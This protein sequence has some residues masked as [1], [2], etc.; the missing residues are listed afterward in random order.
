[1]CHFL[2]LPAEVRNSIYEY[3]LTFPHGL[4]YYHDPCFATDH[5]QVADADSLTNP[6]AHWEPEDHAFLITQDA[7]QLKIVSKQLHSE[8]YSLVLRFNDIVFYD[9]QD[10]TLFLTRCSTSYYRHFRTFNI[11]QESFHK[12][13]PY[14][15]Q[16][17]DSL[18]QV[19]NFCRQ[20]PHIQVRNLQPFDRFMNAQPE[21]F[22]HYAAR[23]RYFTRN[24]KIWIDIFIPQ[25]WRSMPVI[26]NQFGAIEP[27]TVDLT[28]AEATPSNFRLIL[29]VQ[30]LTTERQAELLSEFR[31]SCLESIMFRYFFLPNVVGGID[32]WVEIA[33][34]MLRNGV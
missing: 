5:M 21:R 15:I 8:T 18:K 14:S 32:R 7:N 33:E 6:L 9:V 13:W 30:L 31:K 27:T 26:Q 22:P 2:D 25:P 11:Q 28:S 16:N 24:Q 12:E 17:I 10:T 3:A 34:D 29:P 1:M 20:A 23:L 4:K 19:F